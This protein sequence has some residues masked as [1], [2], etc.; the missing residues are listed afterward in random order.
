MLIMATILAGSIGLA[1]IGISRAASTSSTIDTP[2]G[3]ATTAP[4]G[5]PMM[6]RHGGPMLDD[7]ATKFGMSA[8]EL[9]SELDSGKPMYQIAAEHGVTFAKEQEERLSDLKTH[10]D[11]MVKVGYMTQSEADSVYASAKANPM[12]GFGPGGPHR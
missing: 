11:D 8:T 10:L 1:G 5:H 6:A 7:M 12:I 4:A 3:M 2:T 9:K